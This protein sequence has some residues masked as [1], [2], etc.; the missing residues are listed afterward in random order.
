MKDSVQSS[1]WLRRMMNSVQ[2]F[3]CPSLSCMCACVRVYVCACV[4][5]VAIRVYLCSYAC[6]NTRAAVQLCMLYACMSG[7][8]TH[9][10]MTNT[11][12]CAR[13]NRKG[14]R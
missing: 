9:T 8:H 12:A 5:D 2:V 4:R 11:H 3:M 14:T 1:T 7:T 13:I 10:C 6:S